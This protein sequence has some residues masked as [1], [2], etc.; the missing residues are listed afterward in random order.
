MQMMPGKSIVLYLVEGIAGGLLT[1]EIRNWT[2]LVLAAPR[3]S[4]PAL[5]QRSEV[6]RTGVYIL[7][8]GDPGSLDGTIAYIGEGDDVGRRLGQ[9]ARA[10]DQDNKDFWS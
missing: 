3:S 10:E 9:H 8:G 7:V 6:R 4:L 2:G 1:A 5:L